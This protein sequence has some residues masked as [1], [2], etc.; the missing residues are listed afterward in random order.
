MISH[1]DEKM[2]MNV[3]DRERTPRPPRILLSGSADGLGKKL[4][5]P[6][7][8]IESIYFKC[9]LRHRSALDMVVKVCECCLCVCFRRSVCG[10][11]EVVFGAAG[12][13]AQMVERPLRMREV[14]GSIPP[15][16]TLY[17]EKCLVY[18]HSV[19]HIRT[20]HQLCM[21]PL[22]TGSFSIFTHERPNRT[23]S[24]SR[25]AYTKLLVRHRLGMAMN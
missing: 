14:G 18:T 13:L 16:S 24:V 12:R 23:L 5:L 17:S 20:F 8:Q 11:A 15:V 7:V 25:T 21:L 22:F 9:R 1:R 4:R 3:S 19:L 10:V 6:V 2:H